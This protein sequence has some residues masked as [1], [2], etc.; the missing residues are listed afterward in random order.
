[1]QLKFWRINKK[2]KEKLKTTSFILAILTASLIFLLKIPNLIAFAENQTI[3]VSSNPSSKNLPPKVKKQTKPKTL[4]L[5]DLGKIPPQFSADAILAQDLNSGKIIYQKNINLRMSPAST[6]KLMTALVAVEY[7]KPQDILEVYP[8]D[9]VG[10]SDMDLTA[11]E[12]LYFRDLLYGMLLNSGNDAAFTIASNYPGGLNMFVLQMNKK[13]K[14]LGLTN[15]RFRNPAGFD[16]DGHY[17]SAFDLAKIAANVV[18]NLQLRRVVAT[19]ETSVM[20]MGTN[21]THYL[22]NLNKLL[23]QV[24]VLGIKT[25]RTEKSG[26]NLIGLVDRNSHKVLT[27]ILDSKDRFGE[28]EALIDWVYSNFEWHWQ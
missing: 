1:M 21:K 25:G 13:A 24:G 20:A 3:L 14:E 9:L 5:I 12:R 28:T 27:V 4:E 17:S 18:S 16:S 26:E 22:R 15:T 8:E 11:G 23:D 2:S 7:F 6:T 10:G 19:K